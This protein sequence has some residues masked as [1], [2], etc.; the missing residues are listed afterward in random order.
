MALV[1]KYVYN[2]H[3][4]IDKPTRVT[5]TTSTIL[6]VIIT[7]DKSHIS[8][9]EVICPPD[10]IDTTTPN[11]PTSRP[12]SDHNLISVKFNFTIEKRKCYK[13]TVWDYQTANYDRISE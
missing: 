5:A 6:D 3:Q 8:D 10:I 12:S 4:L 2:L 1:V 13:R 9:T 11:L 7:N